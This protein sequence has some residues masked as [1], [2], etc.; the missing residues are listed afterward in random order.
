[1]RLDLVRRAPDLAQEHPVR[2]QLALVLREYPQQVELVRAQLHTSAVDGDRALR[3]VHAEVPDL[4]HRL[5]HAGRAAHDGPQPREQLLD[6]ERL[7]HVVVG[8]GIEGR[9]LVAFLTDRG[10]HDHRRLGPG[11]ELARHLGAVAVGEDEIEDHRLGRICSRG[12]QRLVRTRSGVDRVAR[13]AQRRADRA[14][15]LRFVVDDEDALP[16]H[17]VSSAGTS[18]TGRASASVAP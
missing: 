17:A 16:A 11:T 10:K 18:T 4:E 6:A 5:L 7:G 2:E 8:P 12:N 3:H 1:V 9:D 14:Q 13:A 15:D